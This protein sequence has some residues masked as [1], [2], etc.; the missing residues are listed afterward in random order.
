MDKE[1]TEN[2]MSIKDK[3]QVE[4]LMLVLSFDNRK[5]NRDLDELMENVAKEFGMVVPNKNKYLTKEKK[6]VAIEVELSPEFIDFHTLLGVYRVVSKI[7]GFRDMFVSL[8]KLNLNNNLK[9]S[10]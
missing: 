7:N 8:E 2:I 3:R 9:K 10:L 4:S 5:V 6:V 1:I